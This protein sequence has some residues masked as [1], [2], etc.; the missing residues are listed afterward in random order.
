MAINTTNATIQMRRGLEQDFDPDKLIPGEWAVSLDNKYV[1]MCFAPG[2]VYRMATYES[3]EEDMEE[4]RTI[5]ATC[6]NIQDAVEAMGKLAEQHMNDAEDYSKLSESWAHGHTGAREGEDEDNSKY[7]S[8]QSSSYSEASKSWAIGEGGVRPDEG[9]NNSKYFAEQA[10]KIVSAAGGGA[11]IPMGTILFEN[12]PSSDVG[13]GQMYNISNDFSSDE[14]FEDGGGILYSA[15]ANVYR[16]AGGKWDV[17]TGASVLS[18]NG[19]TGNV[20]I[21]PEKIGLGNVDNTPDE[22]KIVEAAERLHIPREINGTSFDG[23]ENVRLKDCYSFSFPQIT[24]SQT[25]YGFGYLEK[26]DGLGEIS[27]LVSGAARFFSSRIGVYLVVCSGSDDTTDHPMTVTILSPIRN[28]NNMTFGYWP[29]KNGWMFGFLK[30]DTAY[31][32]YITNIGSVS[33][34]QEME[35]GDLYRGDKPEGWVNAPVLN[36]V[37]GENLEELVGA[38]KNGPNTNIEYTVPDVDSGYFKNTTSVENLTKALNDFSKEISGEVLKTSGKFDGIEGLEVRE[39]GVY[40]TY[41]PEEGADPVSKK[42]YSG[43]I[44]RTQILSSN[45]AAKR[46]VNLT[47]YEGWQGFTMDNFC[48]NKCYQSYNSSP[49]IGDT[50]PN[51]LASYN[52]ETGILTLNKSS[53]FGGDYGFFIAYTVDLIQVE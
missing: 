15:G 5:L 8:E 2:L 45:S 20:N 46:T 43:K 53:S 47:S 24:A 37:S 52:N 44:R 1:R 33:M 40:I 19:E 34:M 14:R 10:A 42:L 35:I 31:P 21:T 18:V 30:D 13:T 25:C 11:L 39:D 29:Y 32:T 9:I 22:E 3:F 27:V 23:T 28:N 36:A 16:T 4:I 48:I 6:Q 17:L 51:I 12:L 49:S 41:V 38:K 50:R 26:G 7:H